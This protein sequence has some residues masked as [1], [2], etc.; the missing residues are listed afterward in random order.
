MRDCR[1]PRGRGGYI[2]FFV[3]EHQ[4][5]ELVD[6]QIDGRIHGGA[7]GVGVQGATGKV[8]GGD[9]VVVR[10]ADGQL[11]SDFAVLVEMALQ[12]LQL[13]CNVVPQG[14]VTSSWWPY[15][16]IRI[17]YLHWSVGQ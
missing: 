9:H 11:R 16:S 6:Q 14:G 7:A 8:D 1:A 13:A 12:S 4:A 3:L 15:V 10:L 2:S 5:V 17:G